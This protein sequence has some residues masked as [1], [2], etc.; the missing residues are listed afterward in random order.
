MF[1]HSIYL[2]QTE[3][4]PRIDNESSPDE[5]PI[6]IVDPFN[7]EYALH[8]EYRTRQKE[9]NIIGVTLRTDHPALMIVSG[10][11]YDPAPG[12]DQIPEKLSVP[13]ARNSL[14]LRVEKCGRQ[15]N[16]KGGPKNLPEDLLHF[17]TS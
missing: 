1:S 8:E 10:R 2:I 15:E 13:K 5:R 4:H 9:R 7:K 6:G 3:E 17:L 16:E 14:Q 12:Q 11:H